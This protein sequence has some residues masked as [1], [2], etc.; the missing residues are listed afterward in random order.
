M[1]WCTGRV[2]IAEELLWKRGE[3]VQEPER[4]LWDAMD[5]SSAIWPC[6]GEL[7]HCSCKTLSPVVAQG[8]VRCG[9][10]SFRRTNVSFRYTLVT[11]LEMYK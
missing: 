8:C 10:H 5:S 6:A 3:V 1:S 9:A 7:G 4:L 2:S 11:S